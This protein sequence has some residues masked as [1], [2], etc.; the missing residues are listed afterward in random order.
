MNQQSIHQCVFNFVFFGILFFLSSCK[1][2]NSKLVEG[3][4]IQDIN[5]VDAKKGLQEGMDV[6]LKD[7]RI[8]QVSPHHKNNF[9]PKEKIFNG[10]GKYVLPGLWDTHVHFAY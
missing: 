10:K 3:Y 2:G 4:L 6:V 1:N 7:N 8:I 5:I 9:F